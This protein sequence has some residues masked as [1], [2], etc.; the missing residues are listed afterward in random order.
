MNEEKLNY[1][2]CKAAIHTW[3][4][5]EIEFLFF[6]R[7]VLEHIHNYTIPQYGDKPNDE[8]EQW[9]PEQCILAIQKYTKR[10]GS[11][12]RGRLEE[13]RDIL[14]MAHFSAIA[15]WKMK[16][17]EEELVKLKEGKV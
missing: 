15:F 3:T 2:S 8:V 9:T 6:H 16:P 11:A 14:K 13:L 12:R 10:S 7:I 5:R 1:G 4:E 17:T